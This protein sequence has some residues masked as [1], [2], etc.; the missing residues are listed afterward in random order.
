MG[1]EHLAGHGIDLCCQHCGVEALETLTTSMRDTQTQNE[2]QHALQQQKSLLD[3]RVRECEHDVAK[4]EQRQLQEA[5][6]R[7]E[8]R[9]Q[10]ATAKAAAEQ[11]AAVFTDE[12]LRLLGQALKR[13]P[14]GTLHRWEKISDWVRALPFRSRSTAARCDVC[15]S[16]APRT[17]I[18]RWVAGLSR[19]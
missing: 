9:A 8:Q 10:A 16:P 1:D 15:H 12:E 13:F 19:R 17:G 18:C 11:A 2:G 14:G 3:A 4:A 7:A 5:R 6:E